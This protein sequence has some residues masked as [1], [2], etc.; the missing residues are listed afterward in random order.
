MAHSHPTTIYRRTEAG[1]AAMRD[2]SSKVLPK[3][4]ALLH[5]IDGKRNRLDLNAVIIKLS[6]PMGSIAELESLGLVEA[7]VDG[8]GETWASDL[9]DP[10]VRLRT[11]HGF[12]TDTIVDAIGLRAFLFIL[13]LERCSS[14]ADYRAL[15]ERHHQ[16]ISKATTPQHAQV[17]HDQLQGLIAA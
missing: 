15:A 4:R 9:N 10:V 3:L 1:E 2:R 14:M 7:M 11:V 5:F 16:L 8:A 13:K 12:M 6:A 17:I